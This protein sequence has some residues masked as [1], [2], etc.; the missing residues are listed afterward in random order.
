[1]ALA[2]I[3]DAVITTDMEGRITFLNSVGESLTGWAKH[4]AIGKPLD[5]VFNIM[6]ESDRQ[7]VESPVARALCNGLIIGLANHT[8]LISRDGKVCKR[9][10]GIAP[11][12]QFEREIKALL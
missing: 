1:V 6:S 3:G 7:P 8:L 2:S 11:K 9:H 10:L 12:S 5:S 4:D